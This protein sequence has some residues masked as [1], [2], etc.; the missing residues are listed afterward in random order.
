EN[1]LELARA[2]LELPAQHVMDEPLA[3][4]VSPDEPLG[5]RG[6]CRGK[7]DLLTGQD[8]E[9]VPGE[10]GKVHFPI[11]VCQLPP[12]RRHS[13]AAPFPQLPEALEHLI[14]LVPAVHRPSTPAVSTR[15]SCTAP[16]RTKDIR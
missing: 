7:G 4:P 8:H 12:Q 14:P 1:V 3:Y 16:V 5:V 2:G 13:G 10:L 9:T 15:N 6:A 11:P